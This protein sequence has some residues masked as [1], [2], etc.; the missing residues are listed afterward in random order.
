VYRLVTKATYEQSLFET[1]AKKYG[2]DEAVL[3]GGDVGEGSDKKSAKEDAKKINDLLKFGVHGAL[4]DSSG[5]EAA[6]FAVGPEVY[7]LPRHRMPF[8]SINVGSIC[9]GLR[10]E[11]YILGPDRLI[12]TS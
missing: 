9:V 1:S 3:G 10:G 8:N 4:R 2:L 6:A 12:A 11:P 7:C 5:E